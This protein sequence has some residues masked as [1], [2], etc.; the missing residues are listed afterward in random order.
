MSALG[1]RLPYSMFLVFF[2][3][4]NA[5]LMNMLNDGYDVVRAESGADAA[6][7]FAMVGLLAALAGLFVMLGLLVLRLRNAD[8]SGWWVLLGF[9]PFLN[10][11]VLIGAAFLPE[12]N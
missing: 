10:F 3:T 2:T 4:A 8:R 11:A 6:I 9:I 12:E 5:W 7:S 1:R